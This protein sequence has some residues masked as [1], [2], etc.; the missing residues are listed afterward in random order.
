MVP[1]RA[2]AGFFGKVDETADWEST[3]RMIAYIERVNKVNI[4]P[5]TLGNSSKL[6][7]EV[8]FNPSWIRMI[9]DNT[10]S[11]LGWIQFEKV[12]WLQNNNPEVPGLVYKL[13]PMDEKMRKLNAVRK[14]WDAVLEIDSFRCLY[15]Q[16]DRF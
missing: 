1:Y 8:Y 16:S 10:V 7:K 6:K 2:L 14:L 9:Q 13:V 15:G 5:Y 12:K 11:I 3:R 4:L